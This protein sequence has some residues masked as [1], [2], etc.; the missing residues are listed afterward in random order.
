MSAPIA[1]LGAFVPGLV[2]LVLMVRLQRTRG[3]A[4][5]RDLAAFPRLQ[6]LRRVG[7]ISRGAGAVAALVVGGVLASVDATARLAAVAPAAMGA[8]MICAILLGQHLTRDAAF[9]AGSASLERRNLRT[10][11]PT[12][13]A[14]TVGV[15]LVL[16]ASILAW[17]TAVAGTSDLGR[18]SVYPYECL[19]DTDNGP[20]WA[21]GWNGPFPGGYYSLPIAAALSVLCVIAVV[22]LILVARRPRNGADAELVRLDDALRRQTSEGILASVGLAVSLTLLGVGLVATVAQLGTGCEA[23]VWSLVT[24]GLTTV[25]A[26]AGWAF[27]LWFLVHALFTSSGIRS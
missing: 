24:I 12:V 1:L 11:V 21:F 26:L 3:R 9:H 4:F 6:Q 8:V 23:S 15:V 16:L 25:G 17:S 2:V 18:A 20:T 14:W 7:A 5:V 22:A 27:S 10:Y 19:V 13:L